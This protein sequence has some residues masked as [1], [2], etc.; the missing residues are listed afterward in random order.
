[1]MKYASTIAVVAVC[2]ATSSSAWCYDAERAK[3]YA[4]LFSSVQGA[5]AGNALHLM[6]PEKFIEHVQAGEEMVVVDV[7]TPA[8]AAVFGMTLPGSL[9]I[10]AD[11]LFRPEN[12]DRIPAD[13]PVVVMCQSGV[14]STAVATAL[15]HVG[16]GNAFIL[17]GGFK[18]LSAYLGPGQANP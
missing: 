10:S 12:L 7:R 2:L 1:M 14:R 6:S 15:R 8:E 9:A 3:G 13:R 4:E 18:A 17:K 16:F 11:Q 5:E